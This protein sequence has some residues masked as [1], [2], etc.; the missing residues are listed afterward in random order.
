MGVGIEMAMGRGRDK[1]T[2]LCNYLKYGL[3]EG[4]KN[5]G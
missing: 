5:A 1:F 2:I 4:P 3:V